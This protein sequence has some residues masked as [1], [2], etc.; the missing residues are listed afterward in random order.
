MLNNTGKQPE[1]LARAGY[2]DKR[3]MGEYHISRVPEGWQLIKQGATRPSKR[4]LTKGRLLQETERFLRGKDATL[5][6]HNED[7]STVEKA[8]QAGKLVPPDWVH[9][10]EQGNGSG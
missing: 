5:V 1:A 3:S 2:R 7:G 8:Y 6:I 10:E 9:W 4:A